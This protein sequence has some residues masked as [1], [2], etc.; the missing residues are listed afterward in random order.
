MAP[1]PGCG[2]RQMGNVWTIVAVSLV[3]SWLSNATPAAAQIPRGDSEHLVDL[4]DVTLRVL[5]YRPGCPSPSL[6]LVFHGALRNADS[7]RKAARPLGSRLC[8]IVV[9]PELDRETFPV[10]SYQRGGIVAGSRVQDPRRWTGNVVLGLVAW[11]SGQEHRPIDY[12]LIGHSAGGQFLSRVAA[13]VPTR[14]KRIVIANPSTYV[15]P[16]LGVD[17]PYGL[18]GVFSDRAA[19]AELRRYLAEPVTIFIGQ[20]DTGERMLAK[21]RH[22]RA[23][24][25]T[26]YDRGINAFTAGERMARSR[27]WA[28]HW[29]LVEVP[30]VGHNA[31]KM[32]SS[33]EAIEALRP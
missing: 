11:V 22:A 21:D 24:G 1:W 16:T 8:V 4:G 2:G 27:G 15:F 9:A 12:S 28:F 20:E 3:M 23:Q 30:G 6:L 14:A 26:R 33:P 17:A 7:Y 13:F 5:A 19:E 31:G 32:F 18:G 29:R 25:E 10:S